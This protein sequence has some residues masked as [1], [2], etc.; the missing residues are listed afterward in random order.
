M[1]HVIYSKFSNDRSREFSIV[2]DIV[3]D[4]QKKYVIKKATTHQSQRHIENIYKWHDLLAKQFENTK[5][6]VAPCK[7]ENGQ[8]VSEYMQGNSLED[9][10]D[11]YLMKE[12]PE[13]AIEVI[14]AYL[15]LIREKMSLL[16]FEK[17]DAFEKV[18]GDVVLEKKYKAGYVS[19]IDMLLGNVIVSN[20]QWSLIDYEWTFDFSIPV[21]FVIF[22][23][24]HYYVLTSQSRQCLKAY[25]EH[26]FSVDELR[27]FET[28]ERCFQQYVKG[29]TVPMRD[30][31][32]NGIG[33]GRINAVQMI[34]SARKVVK[35]YADSGSGYNESNTEQRYMINDNHEQYTLN[36][37]VAEG[38]INYRIDPTESACILSD[39]HVTDENG[40]N[41]AYT[42]SGSAFEDGMYICDD[43]PWIEVSVKDRKLN[44][45]NI[46]YSVTAD[47]GNIMKFIKAEAKYRKDQEERN[48]ALMK[49]NFDLKVALQETKNDNIA[50][51][52]TIGDL[53]VANQ[54]ILNSTS[55][56]ISKP[57]R[58]AG[59]AARKVL[60]SNPKVYETCKKLRVHMNPDVKIDEGPAEK[61]VPEII[62]ILCPEPVRKAQ[63]A[64]KFSRKIKFSILVPLY[65]TPERYLR[66]MIESV[67][68]QTYPYWELCLA[69]GSDDE[70]KKVEKI[71]RKYM[72]KDPRIKYKKLEKNLGIS[73]NTNA[74]MDMATGSFIALFDH[75]DFLHPCVLYENMK[76]I[77][78]HGADY[79]YT[80]EAT[81]RGTNLFDIITKHCKP[82]F[83]IDNLRA[84]NYICHFSVF[85]RKLVEKGGRFRSEYDGSQD[86]D[87]ILRMTACAKKVFHIRKILYFWRSHPDSVAADISAKPYAID[88]AKRAVEDH[89]KRCGLEATVESSVAFPTIFRF[90][91]KLNGTPKISILIPNKDN[92]EDLD[93]CLK[94]VLN[95]ST[96]KNYEI[97]IIENNSTKE[98]TF[99]Y[100]EDLKEYPQIKVV[101]FEGSFNYSKVNN[102][103]EKYATGEYL[104]LLN[105]DTEVISEDWIE[106]LLMYA[107]R[108]DVGAV[109]AKLYF[110][111]GTIQH[112]GIVIGLGA[113]RAA[114]HNN[115]A[116]KNDTFG[117]MGK[118][119]YA[120]DVSAV[121][122][123]CLMVRKS[124][125]DD[126]GG[127]DES[128]SVALNDVDF[129]LRIIEKGYLNVF[130]PYSELYHYESKSRGAED[131]DE[132][133]QRFEL[134]VAQFKER[135]KDYIAAGDPYY[136][137]NFSLDRQDYY[138]EDGIHIY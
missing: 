110:A 46:S 105:N 104:I 47:N 59:I 102:F 111:D 114:G 75:D 92:I 63:R 69:D 35:I 123:A 12:G 48:N 24:L 55:W 27:T 119:F 97:I 15:N 16:D 84:N 116:M 118:L 86:H 103:G 14:E 129:C 40:R 33:K 81:F 77:C 88:A 32:E 10:V 126:L 45:L 53:Q 80:D 67:Q 133:K 65:N 117:Y 4:E 122:G 127:L 25:Y 101:Y 90:R 130:T 128:Y 13:K 94:S 7:L 20:D 107:Q 56:K 21:D 74:C 17:T 95:K 50:L 70:H 26:Y 68:Y 108:P 42:V 120:Q 78:E 79:I 39:I 131:T 49:E 137:P 60:Q 43:D 132:K 125:Y 18:F 22:R 134:E 29:D 109:G 87:F 30:L 38:V 99:K 136:N 58:S 34:D 5:L 72:K 1:K 11:D 36:I 73:G 113:H 121:T 37:V 135:W 44:K 51:N 98:E 64:E 112:A 100:Y 138:I 41:I 91:Y 23:V 3:E 82:D 57:V 83:A 61:T 106:E 52:H 115:L 9:I 62:D 96:Y 66:E 89:L 85:S 2:T 93:R 124:I 31:F 19:D 76:A 28:M 6:V 8:L 54:T 71:C